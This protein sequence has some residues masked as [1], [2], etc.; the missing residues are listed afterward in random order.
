M[1][2]QGRLLA[3]LLCIL[4]FLGLNLGFQQ[5]SQRARLE[6]IAELERG[7]QRQRLL[8]TAERRLADLQRE[9]ALLVGFSAD[10]KDSRVTAEERG[11]FLVQLLTVRADLQR[12]R[13]LASAATVPHAAAL[14][15]AFD[16]LAHSWTTVY[17]SLGSDPE[18]AITELATRAE[19][20]SQRVLRELVPRWQAAERGQLE[21]A[22][23]RLHRT[24]R[25]TN[26]ATLLVFVLSSL[27]VGALGYVV[28]RYQ[29]EVHQQL[30]QRVRERT[31]ALE[32][33]IA[34]RR[35]AEEALAS[36]AAFEQLLAGI[37][38]LFLDPHGGELDRQLG[39]ALERL[40]RFLGAERSVLLLA[41]D[42]GFRLAREWLRG[43]QAEPTP[44]L[45]LDEDVNQWL[46]S[47]RAPAAIAER[48][49]PGDAGQRLR[50]RL[51]G[52]A[53]LLVPLFA[54]RRLVGQVALAG[55]DLATLFPESKRSLLPL[56]GETFANALERRR[57][58]EALQR[59][60]ERYALAARGANDG[61]WDWDLLRDEIYVSARWRAMLGFEERETTCSPADWL[62]VVHPDDRAA[63]EGEVKRHLDGASAHLEHEQRMLCGGHE[64]RWMLVRGMAVRDAGGRPLRMAGS[65]TDVHERK[66]AEQQL[67]H[68]ALHDALTGLPNRVLF[69]DRLNLRI[70][71]TRRHP[72]P[73][74]VLFL[75][76]DRFKIVN[77]SLGH[78]RGDQLL[79]AI[80]RRL[81]GCTRPGDTVAR[82]GGDEFAMLLDHLASASDA[83]QVAAR[84]QEIL[85]APFELGGRPVY[86]SASIGIAAGP[87]SYQE[88]D[89][90]LRDADAAM[91]RAKAQG[92]GRHQVFDQG[93]HAMALERLELETELRRALDNDE[94]VLQYQPIVGLA[95][96]VI[97][98]FEAL[99]RWNS[100]R[101]G[102]VLPDR[103][104][105]VAED[106]GL[107]V[108]LTS[109]VLREACRQLA[110]WRRP[111]S[112][113]S[114]LY[115]G[116]NL[117]ARV[118]GRPELVEEARAALLDAGLDGT[119]LQVEVTESSIIEEPAAAREV[120]HG[121][122]KLRVGIC[123]DDFG[124]G[125]S[126]LASL[127]AFPID[128]VKVD[129]SFVSVM[130][131]H[132][133]GGE[134][135]GAVIALAHRLG[136]EVVAEGV[137]RPWQREQLRL[138]QCDAGQG[139]LF[140]PAVDAAEV[141]ALLAAPQRVVSWASRS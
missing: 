140:S 13:D 11:R 53:L 26:L 64:Y 55:A 6:S 80:A 58:E 66:L 116:V 8:S 102:R 39:V 74:A 104:I 130:G 79:I 93:M 15:G 108:P 81:E 2:I 40:G 85:A 42:A 73:Y 10:L 34:E 18:A 83:R 92:R 72:E 123:L 75:D 62:A 94:L 134:I 33:E 77:D 12:A 139:F 113:S 22:S 48:S 36:R 69:T 30:E 129:R 119:C 125:Y 1:T 76:I 117:S 63:M 118:L 136:M 9:L 47:V 133:E 5:W 105:H 59:S 49:A 110:S 109:W 122:K 45:A 27:V 107:V 90:L 87:A 86:A 65:Q 35:R 14:I 96:P 19:P 98:G 99:V 37:S 78:P 38:A 91:Y 106:T 126:S 88:A 61:L 20:L 127:H 95:S 97:L 60:E 115:V 100:P 50:E 112:S 24:V 44:A 131:S 29:L 89:E 135:V 52:R 84:V 51:G 124:T 32:G 21:Q 7:A 56:F 16:Q 43:P 114:A 82:L 3:G 68:D 71:R 70:A 121:L 31:E 138:L 46:G 4:L 137:E 101:L 132:G 103:F 120:L 28:L 41:D 17:E 25:S 57:V 54:G 128:V 141:P 111:D 67:L 23:V